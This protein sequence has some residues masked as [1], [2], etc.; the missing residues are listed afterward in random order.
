MTD[1]EHTTSQRD[2]S[3][4]YPSGIAGAAPL[5]EMRGITKR[6]PGVVADDR[7]DFDVRRGEVHT[8][9]RR[10]RRR[11]EHADDACSTG[12][13]SR[14]RARSGSTASPVAI[15]LARR[16]DRLGI[17]M[18]HQHFMLV[19]TLTVAENVA[20]G[21][22]LVARAATD[23]RRSSDADPR[24]V[25]ALRARRRSGR[26]G[27]AALASA[28]GS[29]SRSSRRSTASASLLILDEPTAVLAPA[30]GRRPLRRLRA[31]GQADGRGLVFISHKIREV[32]ERRRPRSRCSGRARRSGPCDPQRRDPARA[33]RADGRA[34]AAVAGGAARRRPPSARSRPRRQRPATCAATAAS[35]RCAASASRSTPARSSRSPASRERAARA[36]RGDRGPA[37][38]RP[39]A[40]IRLGGAELAAARPAEIRE[41]RS[42]L[43]PGGA[44][45]RRR[46]PGVQRRR[47]PAADRQRRAR[48]TRAS[49]SCATASSADHCE[50]ARRRI[51]RQDADPRHADRATSPAATSRS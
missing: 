40:S 31:D 6:F 12:C 22:A 18:I 20:L 25:R 26:A 21:A 35:R 50:R 5:L 48:R 29:A 34:R 14:T 33:R 28:S 17:G 36:R 32:L 38:R 23:L 39:A 15:A 19:N 8:L 30:G 13:T 3:G 43:R 2:H 10:E 4:R 49:A 1:A 47:E 16:R 46:R 42:R 51:R 27:L 45:A 37:C 41:R 24:A 44:D 7:V 9:V 11:Q